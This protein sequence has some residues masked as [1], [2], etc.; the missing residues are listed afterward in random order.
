[1]EK[2]Q[3]FQ[4]Q[5]CPRILRLITYLAPSIPLEY[6]EVL[7][8]YLEEK[9]DCYVYLLC[10]S[11]WSGPPDDRVDPFTTGDADIGF[12]CA[13][14]FQ[15][16]HSKSSSKAALLGVAPAHITPHGSDLP[17]YYTEVVVHK[18]NCD[19]F[20][21]FEDLRGSVW[22]YNDAHSLSG[23]WITRLE[24]E[25][26]AESTTTF[27]NKTLQSGSH[28]KSIEMILDKTIDG[29]GIDSN[30]LAFQMKAHPK[31][32]DKLHVVTSWGPLPVYPGVVNSELPEDLKKSITGH[33][34]NMHQ[35]P[36][37][38]AKLND[39]MVSKFVPVTLNQYQLEIQ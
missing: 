20:K 23:Y 17:V 29:T 35:E 21:R 22:A 33:L 12:V 38:Q 39:Y 31:L 1:M 8:E 27:F 3:A 4:E 37:W 16:M 26:M 10:E 11:R 34:L 7:K 19:R 2:H 5:E 18:D 9:L 6:F 32:K 30:V 36:K 14:T 25:K 24:L 13:P 28:L 15:R